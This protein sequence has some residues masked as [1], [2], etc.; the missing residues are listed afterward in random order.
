MYSI[1]PLLGLTRLLMVVH[2]LAGNEFLNKTVEYVNYCIFNIVFQAIWYMQIPSVIERIC[3]TVF[4]K[5]YNTWGCSGT[6]V[7]VAV[8]CIWST[9]LGLEIII[10]SDVMSL[11]LLVLGNFSAVLIYPYLF[12][13]NCQRY[14][15]DRSKQSLDDRY[16]VFPNVQSLYPLFGTVTIEVLYDFLSLANVYI[17]VT[18]VIPT[19]DE[20]TFAVVN[21]IYHMAREVLQLVYCVPFLVFS[22]QRRRTQFLNKITTQHK[23]MNVEYFKQLQSQW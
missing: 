4:Y 9:L 17:M 20:S 23:N 18:I 16:S 6:M 15:A 8:A 10:L 13:V 5:T 1:I 3:A 19:N 14:K 7:I 21:S 2:V 22:E 11:V 12:K